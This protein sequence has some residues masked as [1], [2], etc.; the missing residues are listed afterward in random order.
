[1]IE[2]EE[3]KGW[4]IMGISSKWIKSLVRIRKQEKGKSSQNQETTQTTES[5]E[6]VSNGVR[7][8]LY[9]L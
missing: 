7:L 3:R 4:V 8:G 9:N 2:L 1:V 5:S 6:T